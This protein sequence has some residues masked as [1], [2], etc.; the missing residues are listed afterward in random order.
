[1]ISP[2]N[3]LCSLD[4]DPSDYEQVKSL[5]NGAQ[6]G[7]TASGVIGLLMSLVDSANPSAFTM[8]SLTK[9]LQYMKFLRIGYPPKLYLMLLLQKTASGGLNFVP[10]MSDS[11]KEG[12]PDKSLPMQFE[13]HKVHS[14]FLV[15]FWQPLISMVIIVGVAG[16]LYLIETNL[17]EYKRVHSMVTKISPHIRWNLFLMVFCSNYCDL[18]FYTA[19]SF[20]SA[21]FGSGV[22]VLGFLICLSLNT[23]AFFIV[24]FMIQIIVSLRTARSH[25]AEDEVKKQNEKYKM[26]FEVFKDQTLFQQSFVIFFS[27]RAYAYSA[28]VGFFYNYPVVQAVLLLILCIATLAY[29]FIKRPMKVLINYIQL[30]FCEVIILSVNLCVLIMSMID[31]QDPVDNGKKEGFGAF[32]IFMNIVISWSMPVFTGIKVILIIKEYLMAR[33]SK[34]MTVKLPPRAILQNGTDTV[35]MTTL[36][37]NGT[38]SPRKLPRIQMPTRPGMPTFDHDLSSYQ[39]NDNETSVVE[40]TKNY[41]NNR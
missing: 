5:V 31:Q 18:A 32:I 25:N 30:I 19:V 17:Q 8:A 29:L 24:V 20:M 3:K 16:I 27:I 39:I 41:Q 2:N 33:K 7:G 23:L 4:I 35:N 26:V 38:A 40:L 36:Q 10:E 12:I 13:I 9:M 21:N 14:N 22:A 11:M 1:V 37:T 6:A 34:P 15:G 28:V